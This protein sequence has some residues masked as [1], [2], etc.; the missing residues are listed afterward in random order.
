MYKYKDV[1]SLTNKE[2]CIKESYHC[3]FAIYVYL[4]IYFKN[5]Y[6]FGRAESS[7]QPAGSLSFV[8]ACR[9]FSCGMQSLICSL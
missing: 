3:L 7:L 2:I 5:I 8:V 6:V 9:I 4:F 1:F